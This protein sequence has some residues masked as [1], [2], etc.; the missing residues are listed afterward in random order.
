M[1]RQMISVIIPLY[2]KAT[3]I[4]RAIRSVLNQ[5]V[6]DF[7]L[8]VVNNGST[9]GSED[10]VRTFDDQRITLI[11]QDNQGVSMARNRGID[12]SNSEWVTFLDA[13]DEW[14]PTFIETVLRLHEKYEDCNVCA[15]SY[16]KFNVKGDIQDIKLCKIPEGDSFRLD[17]YFE[18]ASESD[19]PFCSI[20]VMVKKSALLS[21]GGFPKGVH[22]GEDLLTWA[23]LAA[24]N[25]IAYC[26]E[27][28]SIFYT[29]ETSSMDKPKRE[30]AKDDI[31]GKELER[32]YKSFPNLVGL[33]HYI[34]KWHKMRA[35]IYLRLP[36]QAKE[37]RK[38]VRHAQQWYHNNRL[39]YYQI[40]SHIPYSLRMKLLKNI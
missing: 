7:E 21:I 11:S 8:I 19:P 33:R 9:D 27:P 40:L 10:V 26:R 20:S 37:C 36:K 25:K 3:T 15:T 6:Q 13:D 1:I 31:V 38:E 12:A 5:T 16:Q 23:R 14:R 28:Q 32:L 29:G 4:E 35:S 39:I 17:N 24:N 22:Q 34:A 2:N 18:V 30:P